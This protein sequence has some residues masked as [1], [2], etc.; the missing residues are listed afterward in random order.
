MLRAAGEGAARSA[1]GR[2]APEQHL[3]RDADA[4]LHTGLQ[5]A[6]QHV[7]LGTQGQ[8]EL[9]HVKH[10][11]NVSRSAGQVSQVMADIMVTGPQ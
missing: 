11:R 6:D 9:Q 3:H 8:V 5:V 7:V 4:V 2:A 1:A 10:A